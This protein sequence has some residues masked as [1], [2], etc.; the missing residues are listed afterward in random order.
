MYVHTYIQY[1]FDSTLIK[2]TA[3][4]REIFVFITKKKYENFGDSHI[5]VK[6]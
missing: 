5:G 1:N 2:G 3:F 4:G 6:T